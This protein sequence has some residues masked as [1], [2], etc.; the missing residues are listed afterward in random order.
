MV[1]SMSK[2]VWKKVVY[3]SPLQYIIDFPIREYDLTKANISVLRDANAITE[4][5][6]QY[7][8]N[9]PKD[10]RNII[11]GKMIGK[12]T[13]IETVRK[14]GIESARRVFMEINNLDDNDI[15]AIRNDAMVVLSDRPMKLD[16][17]DRVKFR[18][19]S[20]YRS[21]YRLGMLDM[22]YDFD[23]INKIE[24]L[25]IKGLGETAIS[26]HAN[27]MLDFLK[28]IFYCAQLEGVG[29]AIDIL[30]KFYSDYINLKLDVGYYRE[31]VS[32]SR[33]RL[34]RSFT[35]YQTIEMDV[36]SESDKKY[37]DISYN[38]NILMTLNKML[39]TSYFAK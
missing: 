29:T 1:K 3:R 23:P 24:I 13:D 35:T 27:Y 11:I 10:E 18:L 21:Y 33:Y 20:S 38:A 4:D 2:S 37:L 31:L 14:A 16:I 28:E 9:C 5:L 12:N 34:N 25:D 6:Y 22:Y 15:L 36:A 7:L 17:T 30:S 32:Q 8:Y 39:A 19:E 26:L